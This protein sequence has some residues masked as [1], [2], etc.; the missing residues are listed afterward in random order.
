MAVGGAVAVDRIAEAQ[1]KQ[2]ELTTEIDETDGPGRAKQKRQRG[3][4]TVR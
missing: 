3:T 2:G 4:N 1:A